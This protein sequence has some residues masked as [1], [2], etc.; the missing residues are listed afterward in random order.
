LRIVIVILIAAGAAMAVP[1][2]FQKHPEI[3]EAGLRM[4]LGTSGD[5]PRAEAPEA[6]AH[7]PAGTRSRQEA[8]PPS[9]RKVR[10]EAGQAGHF[11]A[12]F[13]LNGRRVEALIDTGA[14]TV[15]I[16]E[17]TARR[18]GIS[19]SQAD[20][21]YTVNTANGATS[22]AAARIASLEIG[23]IHVEDVDAAVL[24]DDALA[25][26]LVG[27]SFLKRLSRYEVRD[28]ALLLVQ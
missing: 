3:F 16:N 5:Q 11:V 21:K 8:Q 7:A 1:A 10:I 18:I 6:A 4:V 24:K 22:A 23:R 9:G 20:F 15:A 26:V 28:S 17:T 2:L 25:N 14:S 27:M 13:R 19:L 12:D